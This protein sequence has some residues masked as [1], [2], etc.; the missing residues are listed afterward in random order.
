MADPEFIL[1]GDALWLD[2]A[3]TAP[4]L[5]HRHDHLPD[6]AAYVRWN[7]ALKLSAESDVD[8]DRVRRLRDQLLEMAQ[9]LDAGRTPS[10]ALTQA[11]KTNGRGGAA[12]A[13]AAKRTIKQAQGKIASG[14]KQ[15]GV[16]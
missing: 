12:S 5:P 10:S 8:I 15:I 4:F 13:R 11:I 16:A 14:A 9:Y 3:N 6:H 1:L 7:R 2:F